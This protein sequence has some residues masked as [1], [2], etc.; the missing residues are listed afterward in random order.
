MDFFTFILF[1]C[2]ALF[3]FL[4]HSTIVTFKWAWLGEIFFL[5][6]FLHGK[7]YWDLVPLH[8]GSVYEGM[9]GKNLENIK[10]AKTKHTHIHTHTIF[11]KITISVLKYKLLVWFE[12]DATKLPRQHHHTHTQSERVLLTPPKKNKSRIS[13]PS[14]RV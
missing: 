13:K 10:G 9:L 5:F 3:G 7:C 6:V 12:T 2:I 8:N 14:C 1:A 4:V 11:L